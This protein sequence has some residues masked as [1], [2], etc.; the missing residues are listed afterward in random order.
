MEIMKTDR[1]KKVVLSV[2]L[3][4]YCVGVPAQVLTF[5]KDEYATRRSRLME[6][7]PDGIAII[8]GAPDVTI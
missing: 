8:F 3:G 4:I 1:F 2:V 5:T 7:I 6:K